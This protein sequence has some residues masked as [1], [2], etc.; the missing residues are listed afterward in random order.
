[1]TSGAA[2]DHVIFASRLA[3]IV[4]VAAAHRGAFSVV[5]GKLEP[6]LL[7]WLQADPYWTTHIN[8]SNDQHASKRSR[9]SVGSVERH[10]IFEE[11]GIRDTKRLR[12]P[13]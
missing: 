5:Q 2:M 13:G 1:M 7:Q 10:H 12:S 3:P 6:Q 11:G 9:G 8:A 4:Y